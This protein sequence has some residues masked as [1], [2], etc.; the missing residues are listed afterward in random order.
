MNELKAEDVVSVQI[1]GKGCEGKFYFR[2]K[3]NPD[4][5]FVFVRE[6]VKAWNSEEMIWRD[7][8]YLV[9]YEGLRFIRRPQLYYWQS[10]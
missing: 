6:L 2:L 7:I 10:S 5:A 1:E 3:H 8:I 4:K 9:E